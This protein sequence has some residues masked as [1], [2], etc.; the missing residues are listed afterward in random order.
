VRVG[1]SFFP[2][3]VENARARTKMSG[4]QMVRRG[5]LGGGGDSAND[6]ILQMIMQQKLPDLR[7][8]LPKIGT[9][10]RYHDHI[11]PKRMV[12][13]TISCVRRK[14]KS[15]DKPYEDGLYRNH[16]TVYL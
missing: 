12:V 8:D 10:Y 5:S 9:H 2:Q 7:S 4:L 13:T 16:S 3:T 14:A 15:A 11:F 1:R 6:G